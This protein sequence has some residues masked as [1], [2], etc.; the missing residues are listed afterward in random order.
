MSE[1]HGHDYHQQ[2]A[3]L[4]AEVLDSY[5][6]RRR[7]ARMRWTIRICKTVVVLAA[8]VLCLHLGYVHGS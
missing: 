8:V 3:K 4:M 7:Q 1:Y 5:Y 6:K 2:E